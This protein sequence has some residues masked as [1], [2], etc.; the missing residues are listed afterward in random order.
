MVDKIKL[1]FTDALSEV[2]LKLELNGLPPTKAYESNPL[3]VH[4]SIVGAS[5]YSMQ[6]QT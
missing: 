4:I 2:L 3:N 6:H 5:Q 1:E